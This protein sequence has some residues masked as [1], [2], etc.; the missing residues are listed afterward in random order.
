VIWY[1]GF[2][3][4]CGVRPGSVSWCR[5]I[6]KVLYKTII[7]LVIDKEDTEDLLQETFVKIFKHIDQLSDP[8]KLRYRMIRMAIER[9]NKRKEQP[10]WVFSKRVLTSRYLR[11]FFMG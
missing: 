1:N 8:G 6:K 7:R 3:I 2:V 11:F 4:R 9:R 10:S 5:S